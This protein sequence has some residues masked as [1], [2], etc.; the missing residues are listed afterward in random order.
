LVQNHSILTLKIQI[1]FESRRFGGKK[2]IFNPE[3][4]RIL[5]VHVLILLVDVLNFL[6]ENKDILCLL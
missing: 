4:L 5:I 6:G 2:I 1:S 3:I